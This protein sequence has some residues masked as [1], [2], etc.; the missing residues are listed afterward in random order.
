MKEDLNSETAKEG[1]SSKA[2]PSSSKQAEER[3]QQR[4]CNATASKR[5]ENEGADCPACNLGIHPHARDQVRVW[6]VGGLG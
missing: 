5:S 4:L 3:K 1:A 6:R 2:S